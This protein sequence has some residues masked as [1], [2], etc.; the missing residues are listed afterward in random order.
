MA[1]KVPLP[2]GHPSIAGYVCMNTTQE[3]LQG[4]CPV[5]FS[6]THPDVDAALNGSE[7]F[8]AHHLPVHDNLAAYLHPSH[9]WPPVPGSLP[10]AFRCI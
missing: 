6:S 2:V 8:P 3:W 9:R 10:L 5:T 1:S 4:Y 7:P